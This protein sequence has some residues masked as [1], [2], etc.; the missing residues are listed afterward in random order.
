MYYFNLNL[1]QI[2]QI[3]LDAEGIQSDTAWDPFI[4]Y[5]IVT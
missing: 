2:K 1:N 4:Y 3:S 5:L